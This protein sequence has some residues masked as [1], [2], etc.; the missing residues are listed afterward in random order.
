MNSVLSLPYYLIVMTY[1]AEFDDVYEYFATNL[2]PAFIVSFVLLLILAC[3]SEFTGNF[4]IK[5]KRVT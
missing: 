4:L 3:L 5:S 2:T 1:E